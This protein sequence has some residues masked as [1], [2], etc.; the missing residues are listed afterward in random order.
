V[1]CLLTRRAPHS[2]SRRTLLFGV[3]LMVACYELKKI[4]LI[5]KE[6]KVHALIEV[7]IFGTREI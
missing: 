2:F 7:F 5:K 1:G 3:G 6:K 4:I